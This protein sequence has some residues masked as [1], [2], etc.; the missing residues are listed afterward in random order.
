MRK[1]FF[2]LITIFIF[3]SCTKYNSEIVYRVERPEGVIRDT[4]SFVTFSSVCM[5]KYYD[6]NFVLNL[7]DKVNNRIILTNKY[8]I[9]IESFQKVKIN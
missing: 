3:S 2:I 6:E 9:V 1:I 4:I 7:N 5:V 8:P